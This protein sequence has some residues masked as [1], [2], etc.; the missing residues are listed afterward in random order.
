[1]YITRV[2]WCNNLPYECEFSDT[3]I[4]GIYLT[5]KRSRRGS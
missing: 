3:Y 2:H 4:V 5:K 1:M